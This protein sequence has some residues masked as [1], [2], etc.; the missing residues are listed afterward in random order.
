MLKYVHFLCLLNCTYDLKWP[1]NTYWI[2]QEFFR[3]TK[4]V[5]WIHILKVD[6]LAWLALL[7]GTGSSSS[8]SLRAEGAGN[9]L[10]V[11]PVT[12]EAQQCPWSWRPGRS[13]CMDSLVSAKIGHISQKWRQLTSIT[14]S[15]WCQAFW[16]KDFSLPS[17]GLCLCSRSSQARRYDSPSLQSL[18]FRFHLLYYTP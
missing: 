1:F 8:G 13:R 6:L 3:G 2:N 7:I 5:E 14:G 9:S 15:T 11:R 12:L 17:K 10:A 18:Q 4:T 16:G